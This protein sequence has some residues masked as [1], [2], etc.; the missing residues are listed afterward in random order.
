MLGRPQTRHPDSTGTL[1][2]FGQEEG[3]DIEGATFVEFSR[4]CRFNKP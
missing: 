1:T 3:A 4:G 2:P